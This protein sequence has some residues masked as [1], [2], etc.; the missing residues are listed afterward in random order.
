MIA[1]AKAWV[2]DPPAKG[3]RW[4]R[5]GYPKVGDGKDI[6]ADEEPIADDEMDGRVAWELGHLPGIGA[7][8]MDSWRIFCRDELREFDSIQK[9]LTGDEE[10]NE[11]QEPKGEWARVLPLDKELRAYLRWRW[12]KEGWEWNPLTG[13]RE[14][15]SEDQLKVAQGGGV[16]VEENDG[17]RVEGN[18]DGEEIRETR[19]EDSGVY[20]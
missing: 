2:E 5:V 1:L 12:L 20:I 15:A 14:R 10:L 9:D 4:R 19:T 8:A 6:K 11:K 7:Y 13:E 17:G 18:I 16:V 3:R